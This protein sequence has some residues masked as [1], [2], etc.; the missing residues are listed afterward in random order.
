MKTTKVLYSFLA[1]FIA[2]CLL[3][4]FAL[5][6]IYTTTFDRDEN[7]ISEGGKWIH[8]GLDWALIRAKN[9]KAF[10]TQ[11]GINTGITKYDDS[12]AHLSGFPPDQEAFGIVYISKPDPSC[13]QEV[14]ILLRWIY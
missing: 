4:T 12:Y 7:P 14:E 11:S 9:G 2:Y 10:G 8:N 6:Q 3:P 1:V 5:S 13:Y